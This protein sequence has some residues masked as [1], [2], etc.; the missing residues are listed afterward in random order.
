[1]T[2]R[3][4]QDLPPE[5]CGEAPGRGRLEGRS[6]LVVGG[7]QRTFDAA[8]DPTG[9][10]RAMCQLFA[11]EGANVAVADCDL[12]SAGATVELINGEGGQALA[13]KADIASEA[14]I[15]RMVDEAHSGLGALDGM[16]LNVGVGV[17]GLGLAATTPDEWDTT[18]GINLRGPMLCCKAALP[19]LSNSASIVFIS[20]I[21][22]LTAGSQ[23]VAYD[24]SKAALGGLMRHVAHEGKRNGIR[25]NLIYPGLIDT[26]LG[27]LAS[28]GRPSRAS[29]RIPFGRMATGWEVANAA[30]FFMSNESIYLTAQTL[31]VDGGLTGGI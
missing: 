26:P 18:L 30:L 3:F 29:A 20:S 9:N 13:I 27:R 11:R 21:A 25:A 5:S 24:A 10:G 2:E 8:T 7:G 15:I 22:A 6:I 12:E 14:D 19:K 31:T 1:M 17:G 28:A 16:V 4:E 23:L